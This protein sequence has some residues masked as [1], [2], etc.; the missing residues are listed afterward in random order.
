MI[1]LKE[2]RWIP[3]LAVILGLVAGTLIV[4]LSGRSPLIMFATFIKAGT[5]IDLLKGGTFNPRLVGEFLVTTMPILMGGLSISFAYRTG[6]FNIGAE[7]QIIAGGVAAIG[8][9]FF[10][11]I[12]NQFIHSTI[13]VLAGCLAGALWGLI[14]GL[15]KARFNVHEVVVGIMLNYTA[16]YSANWLYKQMPLNQMTRTENVPVSATLNV[17]FL[18]Q[19]TNNSRLHLGFIHVI[20]AL[21]LFWLIIEK[22]S[23]GYQLRATGFNKEG[24]RFAGIKVKRNL[25]Y[26][27]MIAGAFAG[28]GGAL[29]TLGTYGYGR[30]ITA[31]DNVGFDGI[32]VA[33]V[34]GCTMLGNLFAGLLFGLMKVA[35]PALQ[36]ASI[37]KE[38]GDIISSL[39]VLLVALQYAIVLYRN[40]IRDWFKKARGQK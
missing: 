19:L 28:L 24:A 18:R 34:G 31:F 17:D 38:I 26:S 12:D 20:I 23:F 8:A 32:S 6:L 36:I 4:I 39:I 11:P 16:M 30:V 1:S 13:C 10:I 21:F 15:L 5:G 29:L 33:L 14:P 40:K 25:V 35:Q 27:L 22:T 9:G 3:F 2:K 7:G 37:P